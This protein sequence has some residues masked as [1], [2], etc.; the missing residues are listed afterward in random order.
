MRKSLFHNVKCVSLIAK[1]TFRT[2]KATFHNAKQ[3][4]IWANRVVLPT[5]SSSSNPHSA[6][7]LNVT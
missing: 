5:I 4:I 1:C 3:T 7:D 6:I 2:V